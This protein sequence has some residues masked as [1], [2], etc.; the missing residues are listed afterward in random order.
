MSEEL[1]QALSDDQTIRGQCDQIL[2]G[3]RFQTLWLIESLGHTQRK[4]VTSAWLYS[5]AIFLSL[6]ACYKVL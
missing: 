1:L 2:E 3:R 6:H 4:S 5:G